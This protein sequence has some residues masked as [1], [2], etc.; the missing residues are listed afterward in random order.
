LVAAESSSVGIGSGAGPRMRL[1]S[2]SRWAGVSG[3]QSLEP[4]M[5]SQPSRT[6]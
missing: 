1:S 3:H 5:A 4:S 2:T 6:P